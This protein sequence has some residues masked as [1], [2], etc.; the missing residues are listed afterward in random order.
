MFLELQHMRVLTPLTFNEYELIQE[1]NVIQY[2]A[3]TM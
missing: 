3:T 2:N 1:S